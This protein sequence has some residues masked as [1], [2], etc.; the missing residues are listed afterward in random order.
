[1]GDRLLDP[2][3]APGCGA[4]ATIPG[5]ATDCT[6]IIA[7]PG[8]WRPT[9]SWRPETRISFPSKASRPT[10]PSTLLL[11][12]ADEPDHVENIEGF[13]DRKLDALLAHRSQF[14]STMH[15]TDAR[16]RTGRRTERA[17]CCPAAAPPRRARARQAGL[18]AAEAFKALR[19]L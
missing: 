9:A 13:E 14:R 10:D 5:S 19:D 2:A 16:S 1:M 17:F 7:T 3:G 18:A 6:P 4:R 8:S 12:E 15:I 11:W